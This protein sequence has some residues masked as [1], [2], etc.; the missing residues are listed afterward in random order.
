MPIGLTNTP[1]IVGAM[2]RL[3]FIAAVLNAMAFI[4]RARGTSVAT[5]AWRPGILKANAAP[6]NVDTIKRCQ[7]SM[8]SVM[9]RAATTMLISTSDN[10]ATSSSF[11]LSTRS[12]TTPAIG[13]RRSIGIATVAMRYPR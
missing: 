7:N 12:V 8:V 4:S 6:E 10:C 1:A 11:R 3:A 9:I 13:D 5:N 2:I